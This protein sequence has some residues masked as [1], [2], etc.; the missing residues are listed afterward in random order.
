VHPAKFG[1]NTG[2]G[3]FSLKVNPALGIIYFGVDAFYPGGWLGDATAPG[4]LEDQSRLVK[5][6]QKYIPNFNLYRDTFVWH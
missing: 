3:L 1:V 5:E 2:V 4:A 6:N